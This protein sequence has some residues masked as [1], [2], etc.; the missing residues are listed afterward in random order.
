MQ[1]HNL[2]LKELLL[3]Y[4]CNSFFASLNVK[5]GSI[6]TEFKIKGNKKTH[7]VPNGIAHFLEHKMFAMDGDEDV[8]GLFSKMKQ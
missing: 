5:Y 2:L 7:K 8:M 3:N 6:D 4:K 1:P